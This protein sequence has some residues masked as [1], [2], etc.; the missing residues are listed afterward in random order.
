MRHSPLFLSLHPDY[1]W[2]NWGTRYR[3]RQYRF[4]YNVSDMLNDDV[5]FTE[6]Y[7][8]SQARQLLRALADS[9]RIDD[10]VS[11]QDSYIV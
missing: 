4:E 2:E 6:E 3:R 5:K 11:Q 1:C 8:E 7:I 10:Q 9:R